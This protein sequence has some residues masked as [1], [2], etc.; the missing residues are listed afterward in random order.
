M[1]GDRKRR[2]RRGYWEIVNKIPPREVMGG[3]IGQRVERERERHYIQPSRLN[4]QQRRQRV[5]TM[6]GMHRDNALRNSIDDGEKVE[7]ASN[8]PGSR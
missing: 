3:W 2:T 1:V 8:S 4:G 7:R 5:M 6:E